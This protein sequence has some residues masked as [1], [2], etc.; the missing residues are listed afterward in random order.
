[1]ALVGTFLNQQPLLSQDE[2]AAAPCY[3]LPLSSATP[4][5]VVTYRSLRREVLRAK[6]SEFVDTHLKGNTK[7][8]HF[9][10]QL[11]ASMNTQG[12]TH[13]SP[14]EDAR[15][16]EAVVIEELAK[17]VHGAHLFQCLVLNGKLN[18]ETVDDATF[19]YAPALLEWAQGIVA[20]HH[21]FAHDVLRAS[22]ILP[23]SHQ[24]A[25]PDARCHLPRLPRDEV[26]RV[27]SFL[28]VRSGEQLRHVR[29]FAETLKEKVRVQNEQDFDSA[30]EA[31]HVQDETCGEV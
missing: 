11:I 10:E 15:D 25:S 18:K 8:D 24:Q 9:M 7:P 5:T 14:Q 4:V 26:K 2:V 16:Y 23:E 21:T 17:K 6:V 20:I 30:D 22:V 13:T 19:T 29:E 28:G 3:F 27:A 31:D 1:M 12:S